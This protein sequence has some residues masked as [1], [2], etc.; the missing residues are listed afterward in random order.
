MSKVMRSVKNVTKGYSSVQVKVRNATSNDH[1]GPTG[2]EM[3]EIAQMTFNNSND[4]YE[5]MDMLDK[6]LNDKGKNWRH[7]LKA[8]KVLDYALHEGSELVV[9]WA[10]KNI[11][12]IKTLREFQY[13]DEDDKDVGLNVRTSAKELTSLILDEERLRTE[14]SDR[15]TWKSRVTGIEEYGPSSLGSSGSPPEPRRK[16]QRRER[17]TDE[18]DAEYKLAIEASKYEAEE[19]QKRRNKP[20]Q[21]VDDDDLAKAIKLSKEEEELRRRELEESNAAAIFSDAPAASQP[22]GFNQGYQQGGAVDWDGNINDN[23]ARQ[24]QTAPTGFLNNAYSQPT[25][26]Q[27]Q[28]MGYQNTQGGY[29][30]GFQTQPGIFDQQQY[31]QPQQ[32]QNYMQNQP[33]AFGSNNNPYAQNPYDM[34]AQN[35]QQQQPQQQGN[36]NQAGTNNP[37]TSQQPQS[38][39]ELKPMPTGSNNPFA[40][41]LGRP[42]PQQTNTAP[43][44]DTLQ[45]QKVQTQFNNHN[46]NPPNSFSP[47]RTNPPQKDQNPQHARLN[48]LLASGEG[49]DS[50]GNTGELRIPAH[51]TAPGTFVNSAGQGIGKVGPNQT[52]NNPFFQQQ[53]TGA[54]SQQPSS[55]GFGN[56]PSPFGSQPPAQQPQQQQ[57]FQ[58]QPFQQ[59][60]FQQQ[61]R[62]MPAQTGPANFGY[63]APFGGGAGSTNN[64]FGQGQMQQQG[65]GN[66]LI[67]L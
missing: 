28:P 12:I 2:A 64:P 41:S 1:W 40:S 33:T 58:Q 15:K 63:G 27:N 23:Q 45:E 61:D 55:S 46:F 44:L 16:P 47:Q 3:S 36:F 30:N 65:R 59:Q 25:G 66:S 32:Q 50:F 21:P 22:T 67:D 51:H 29:Q 54:P 13:I 10:R 6:R 18:E 9:N 39:D 19:E 4:F 34:N 43:S 62:M 20:V 5:I 38:A 35:Q 24:Q 53:V 11:Y 14:R 31:Q 8:L 17:R 7:V 49:L 57:P 37:Y 56:S 42:P 60:S 48:A 26:Y 52:G